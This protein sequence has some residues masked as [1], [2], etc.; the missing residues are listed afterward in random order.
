MNMIW[1]MMLMSLPVVIFLL[2]EFTFGLV[3]FC[4]DKCPKLY[5]YSSINPMI[6]KY[7]I[8]CD[9]ASIICIALPFFFFWP[10]ME[11]IMLI[12]LVIAFWRV[13]HKK[14]VTKEDVELTY[15]IKQITRRL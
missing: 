9:D 2:T 12:E 6:L 11:F 3:K 8:N 14:A 1:A 5:E 4:Y 13:K 7:I 10:I 15:K